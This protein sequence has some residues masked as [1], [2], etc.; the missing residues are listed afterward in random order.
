MN[1]AIDTEL[2]PSGS[3]AADGEWTN[4]LIDQAI[5]RMIAIVS[6]TIFMGADLARRGEWLDAAS[7]YTG[8]GFYALFLIK[9]WPK[10]LRNIA[11][12]FNMKLRSLRSQRRKALQFLVPIIQERRG[13]M[14]RGEKVPDDMLRWM[15]AKGEEIPDSLDDEKVAGQLLQLTLVAIHT[16]SL[17]MTFL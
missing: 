10:P 16:T 12:L 11:S 14:S 2:I 8:T 6:G 13:L 17:T 5:G 7:N 15:L 3:N 9:M 1:E 4:I